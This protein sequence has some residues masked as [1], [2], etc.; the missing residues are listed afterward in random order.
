MNYQIISSNS[1]GNAVIIE[2]IIL[3]DC[4]VS[5]KKLKDYYKNLKLVL[6]T[7]IHGDHLNRKTIEK[8]AQEKPML[9]FGCCEWLIEDLVNCG[10]NKENIDVL[11][12]DK[13]YDYN[14]FKIQ[15]FELYHDVKNCGY[16][17]FINNKKIIYA[18][19]T[20]SL[21]HI[22]AKNYDLYL[23]EGNY[24]IEELENRIKEKQEK[25]KYI[26]E[27]RVKKTH[28]SKEEVNNWLVEN[29]G[30]NSQFIYMHE[31]CE[32]KEKEEEKIQNEINEIKKEGQCPK[33]GLNG[34]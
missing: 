3:V 17:L 2:N 15:P 33:G 21:D 28:L 13:T 11:E 16:K 30:D 5:F 8:L 20:T 32:D 12:L 26:Y 14:L 4:G 1:K 25:G 7:H 24:E 9:R 23:V 31:H 10:V 18:T 27:F 22:E 34:R 6:L 29:M 19:D